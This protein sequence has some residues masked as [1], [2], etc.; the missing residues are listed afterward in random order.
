MGAFAGLTLEKSVRAADNELTPA[1]KAEGWILLFNGTDTTGWKN[2]NGKPVLAKIEDGAINAHDAGGGLLV[3]D[4]EFGDFILKC[5][6]KMDQPYCNSGIF[7]RTGDLKNIVQTGLEVQVFSEREPDLHGFGAIYD[8]VAPSKNASRG[9]GDWDSVE[10]RCEGPV[11]EVSVNGEKV[12][13]LNCDEWT[14]RRRRPDGSR[15][16]FKK[17]IKDF[18]RKG[19]VG[20]QDH[21]YNVWFKNI[22]LKEL[23]PAE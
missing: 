21:H 5:D 3:Y 9:A 22:K 23:T 19:Y 16:K 15:H 1:E 8:L 10:I 17:A 12:T 14:E 7:V 20:L 4:K 2:N 13:S 18:P 11:V 6:V